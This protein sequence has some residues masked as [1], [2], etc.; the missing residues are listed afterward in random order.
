MNRSDVT[1]IPTSSSYGI[2][3]TN[4]KKIN[5]ITTL[6]Y[7]DCGKMK[8][9]RG[10]LEYNYTDQSGIS[11]YEKMIFDPIG[12]HVFD[13]QGTLLAYHKDNYFDFQAI[14][15]Q[16]SQ[17]GVLQINFYQGEFMAYGPY[18]IYRAT[19]FNSPDHSAKISKQKDTYLFINTDD[20][21]AMNL[22]YADLYS[23]DGDISLSGLTFECNGLNPCIGK[24]LHARHISFS[25][26]TVQNARYN[27]HVIE[28]SCV[29]DS[30]IAGCTF[31]NTSMG[32]EIGGNNTNNYE[33][34]QIESASSPIACPYGKYSFYSG[35]Y[36]SVNIAV[37]D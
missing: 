16:T 21:S 13:Q 25:A 17:G 32:Y 27:G 31:T 8:C 30:T 22:N 7:Q 33:T 35:D 14:L 28:V 4:Q 2:T 19:N 3:I 5:A 18:R 1:N 11:H 10:I 26:C 12:Y 23:G 34:I 20:A 15:N 24:F 29:Q 37:T 6:T 36:R 9:T